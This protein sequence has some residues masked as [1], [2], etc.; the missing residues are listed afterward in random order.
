MLIYVT[1]GLLHKKTPPTSFPFFSSLRPPFSVLHIFHMGRRVLLCSTPPWPVKQTSVANIM[2]AIHL[3][4]KKSRTSDGWRTSGPR[5]PSTCHAQGCLIYPLYHCG[6]LSPVF[7]S[8]CSSEALSWVVI[9]LVY[10]RH[11][12]HRGGHRRSPAETVKGLQR[13]Q[14]LCEEAGG[15]EYSL[16]QL[17]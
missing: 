10:C 1:A 16:H 15:W 17:W 8:E 9:S 4:A 6:S 3:E 13:H 5:R 14:H 7:A 11:Q 2:R 12:I